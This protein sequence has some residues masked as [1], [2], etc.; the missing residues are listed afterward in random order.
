MEKAC[1]GVLYIETLR[2]VKLSLFLP[3]A[4][5]EFPTIPTERRIELFFFFLIVIIIILII[6]ILLASCDSLFLS[7]PPP[8]GI[9]SVSFLLFS[10]GWLLS[11]QTRP[12][13]PL[14]LK[15]LFKVLI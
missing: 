1:G 10:S 2:G 3:A 6:L 7:S 11:A 9:R 4:A 5:L 8:P 13:G 12:S 15:T 14:T